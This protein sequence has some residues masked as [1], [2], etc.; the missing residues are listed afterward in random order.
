MHEKRVFTPTLCRNDV[1]F[2]KQNA[3]RKQLWEPWFVD[4]LDLVYARDNGNSSPD[5]HSSS[6][7]E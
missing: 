4:D 6:G 1:R 7:E 3:S 2:I 5:S